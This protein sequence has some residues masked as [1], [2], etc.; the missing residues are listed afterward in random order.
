MKLNNLQ[1]QRQQELFDEIDKLYHSQH[2][3]LI[4]LMPSKVSLV[5][6]KYK[7]FRISHVYSDYYTIY[8]P[9]FN[10]RETLLNK[11]PTAKLI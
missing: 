3:I 11:T 1:K 7:Y 4:T 2:S 6:E 9:Y 10:N 5:Q 8:N